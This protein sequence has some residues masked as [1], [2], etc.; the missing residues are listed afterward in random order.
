MFG[1][2]LLPAGARGLPARRGAR[3]I[4]Y[5]QLRRLIVDGELEPG[6]CI[7]EKDLAARL[8][9]SRTPLRESIKALETQGFMTRLPNG[10]LM[11]APLNPRDLL[12][13]FATR[14]A[15]ERLIVRS[16]AADAADEDIEEALDPVV[17]AIQWGLESSL[18]ESRTH[19][20]RFHF[21]LASLCRNKVAS[22]ILWELGD[23][24]ALYRR[25]GPD[26][27]PDRRM[28][29]AR[30]HIRIYQLITARQQ[31]EAAAAMEE[32]IQH[33]QEVALGFLTKLVHTNGEEIHS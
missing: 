15:I 16:V 31:E 1:Q 23:R 26:R 5:L 33:S 7:A 27:S 22:T 12:D 10:R 24:I 11:V 13:L 18:P 29:A 30:E 32:H 14:A 8:G 2:D 20:E 21:A 9:L 3:D 19:G 17:A 28:Q 6:V 25:I 4:A